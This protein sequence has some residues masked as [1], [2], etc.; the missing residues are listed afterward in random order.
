[1]FFESVL[2]KS[3]ADLHSY[4]VE[5][6]K[7]GS[8]EKGYTDCQ[9]KRVMILTQNAQLYGSPHGHLSW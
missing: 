2:Y 8:K 7:V 1:M 3:V 5:M 6:E 9:R 4:C